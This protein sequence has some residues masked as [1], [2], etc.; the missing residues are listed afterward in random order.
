MDCD[1]IEVGDGLPEDGLTTTER[2]T[3][4]SLWSIES[5]VWIMGPDLTNLDPYDKTLLTNSEVI[6]VDQDNI[7]APRVVGTSTST[8]VVAAKTEQNGNVIVALFNLGAASQTVSTTTWALG[9]PASAGGYK[10]HDLWTPQMES[11]TLT[12]S[13]VHQEWVIAG[14][15]LSAVLPSHGVAY[16][17]ITPVSDPSVAPPGTV[18]LQRRCVHLGAEPDG[19]RHR[20]AHQQR[21]PDGHRLR[22]SASRQAPAA[23]RSRPSRAPCPTWRPERP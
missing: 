7:A 8:K 23:G 17:R 21:P 4:M 9:L 5:S 19:H 12:G 18:A 11:G 3:M 15:T 6:A 16:Y 10:V 20:L 22:P 2:M 1:S 14:P 13:T